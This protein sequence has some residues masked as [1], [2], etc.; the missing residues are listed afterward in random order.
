MNPG[1]KKGVMMKFKPLYVEEYTID[2][3][4]HNILFNMEK[5][6]YKYKI[7]AGSFAGSYRYELPYLA[8]YIHK[9]LTRPLA[10]TIPEGL[11]IS[12]PTTEDDIEDYFVN[13]LIDNNLKRGEDYRY[14]QWIRGVSDNSF[15]PLDWVI[16]HFE[17]KGPGTNHCC[18]NVG[19]NG[20]LMGYDLDPPMS[21]PCLRLIDFKI[22]DGILITSVFFRS[23]DI[24]AG[25]PV[26]LGG[27]ALLGEFVANAIDIEPYVKPGPITFASSGAHCYDYQIPFLNQRTYKE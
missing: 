9:P 16:K 23:W 7:D 17:S 5:H 10:V 25:F 8:G 18:I 21:T 13:Y 22:K 4:W 24:W 1:V 11:A 12:P 20:M 15:N 27:I 3:A 2:G 6:A 19:S 14:S 26:N